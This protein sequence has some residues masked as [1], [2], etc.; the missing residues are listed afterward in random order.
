MKFILGGRGRLGQALSRQ[1]AAGGVCGLD[2]EVYQDWSAE[3]GASGAARFFDSHAVRGDTVLVAS[4]LLDPA[5]PAAELARINVTL[6][7]NIIA[8]AATRG[9]HVLTFG[10]VMETLQANPNPYVR[11]KL[12]LAGIAAVAAATQAV[13]HIRV[14][15]LYGA[16][17]P[18]PFMFLGQILTSLRSGTPFEMTSGRQLREYHHVD[19]EARAIATLCDAGVRG[20]FDLSSGTPVTL[21]DLALAIFDAFDAGPLLR[22][23]A[24][25]EPAEENYGAVFQA[26]PLLRA[27][28]FR[29]TIPSVVSYLQAYV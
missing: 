13:T 18:S 10:T 25:P 3:D 9:L 23:G 15:T 12:A 24:R 8:A 17:E 1:F 16:G 28:D 29:P 21:R 26:H 22:L 11:S 2:R 7:S 20:V 14:H 4:G 19:D 27:S 5:L 6:P